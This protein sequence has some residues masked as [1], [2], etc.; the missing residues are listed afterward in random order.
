[1]PRMWDKYQ[2]VVHA[3]LME[4]FKYANTMQVPKLQKV[5]LNMGLGEAIQNSKIIDSA[6][7][8]LEAITGQKPVVRKARKAIANF[9]L[10]AGMPIGC[11]V[12]LRKD[13]MWEFVDR[14]ISYAL[15]R[16][17]DFKG[18]NKKGFDG[19]GNYSVGIKEQIIFPEVDYDKVDKIKGLNITFV[20]TAK[21]DEESFMLLKHLG[22]PFSK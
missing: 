18:V 14:F 20:T 22:M 13:Q 7:T 11:S 15:P 21:S 19:R 2:K 9:K 6:V 4:E 10:R 3:K 8:E 17:R 12:T 5:V 16:V 1:M